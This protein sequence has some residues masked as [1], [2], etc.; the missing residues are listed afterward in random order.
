MRAVARRPR[1]WRA[2]VRQGRALVPPRWWR[3]A[4]FLPLPDR[5]W[6]AFRLT[7]AYGDPAARIVADDLV[8]WLAWSETV[9][10]LPSTE[11]SRPARN[12]RS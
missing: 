11:T 7:T 3:R 9:Q 8:T 10:V 4:P 6:T 1:L 5:D 2:A 12:E